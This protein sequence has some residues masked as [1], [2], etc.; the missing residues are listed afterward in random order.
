MTGKMLSDKKRDVVLALVGN[1]VS[2]RYEDLPREVV[3][4]VK[5]DVLDTLGATLAGSTADGIKDLRE[6]VCDWGGK[7][8]STIIVYGDKVPSLNAALVNT[9]MAHACDYDDIHSLSGVHAGVSVIPPSLA[10]A[11]KQGKVTG[12]EFITA[13]ALGI[14]LACRLGI[15]VGLMP[16]T[17][18]WHNTSIY[19]IFGATAACGKILALDEN[20]MINALGIAYSQTSGNAQCMYDGAI[21]KR[22]Q[23]GFAAKAAIL[24]SLLA[25]RG[26]TGAR[27]SLEGRAGLFNLYHR[28]KYDSAVLTSD[29]GKSFEICNLTFKPYPSCALTQCPIGA[30][31]ELVNKHNIKPE[32]IDKIIVSIG[33]NTQHIVCEP[34]EAKRIPHGVTDAQFSLP[35]T[36][37][38]AVVKRNLCLSDFSGEAL[39]NTGVL[40]VAQRVEVRLLPEFTLQKGLEP[41]I[42][43]IKTLDGKVYSKR[44]DI[45]K[46]DP[47]N[48]LTFNDMLGKFWDCASYSVKP[49]PKHK[50]EEAIELILKL[51]TTDDVSGVIRL[52]S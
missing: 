26:F 16:G 6:L 9:T 47:R 5:K 25:E 7:E 49:I 2:I 44:M 24:S 35:Y 42:I 28:G 22:M 48:P 41:V 20:K 46:G 37:A 18:G 43:E 8:E 33:E 3:E 13:V 23:P 51:E 45:P 40:R 29:L 38:T 14:D 39:Q 50:I 10:I 31:I 15:S 36:V 19:G 30:T 52:L 1:V 11:E 32:E 17:H 27:N 4:V 34:L 21:S 12:K